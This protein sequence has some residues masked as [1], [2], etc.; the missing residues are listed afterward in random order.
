MSVLWV[1]NLLSAVAFAFAHLPQL[2]PGASG[3]LVAVA[4][5]STAAGLAMGWLYIRHGLISAVV[6]HFLAD[7]V[8]YVVPRLAAS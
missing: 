5:F 6:G 7:V 8:V 3:F 1:G 2:A 4:A